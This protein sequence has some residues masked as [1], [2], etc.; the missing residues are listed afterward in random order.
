MDTWYNDATAHFKTFR[1]LEIRDTIKSYIEHDGRVGGITGH[2]MRCF[3]GMLQTGEATT[4]DFMACGVDLAAL[5]N[6]FG[7]AN[8]WT[9]TYGTVA[10][11]LKAELQ[12]CN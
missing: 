5:A 7:S 10:A 2:T 4:A 6:R 11:Q 8:C 3:L 1:A 9:G 12:K